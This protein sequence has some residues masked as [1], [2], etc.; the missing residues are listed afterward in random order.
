MYQNIRGNRG[1]EDK[2]VL[3]CYRDRDVYVQTIDCK[4][5]VIDTI[6]QIGLFYNLIEDIGQ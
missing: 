4:K 6:K 1:K 2:R 3:Y 5:I